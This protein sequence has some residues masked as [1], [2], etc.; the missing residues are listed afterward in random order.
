M[1]NTYHGSTANGVNT[2]DVH[3]YHT[4]NWRVCNEML[5][6]S[7]HRFESFH[8]DN[9]RLGVISV[10]I[11]MDDKTKKITDNVRPF[12]CEMTKYQ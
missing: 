11:Q 6:D 2:E 1:N 12:R 7:Y 4:A 8:N 5:T 10:R 9:L 3:L